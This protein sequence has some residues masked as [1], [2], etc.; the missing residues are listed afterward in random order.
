MIRRGFTAAA[1]TCALFLASARDAAADVTAFIGITP[2]PQNHTVRGFAFG[3]G[4]LV[5]GF[6]FEYANVV[7]DAVEGLPALRTGS[8]NV[9]LQMPVAVYGV[10][11]YGT[12]GGTAYR[13]TL[14]TLQET[15]WGTNLG[16]GAKI[17]LAGPLR[18]RLDYRVFKLRGD[19]I[20][21]TYQ[22]FYAGANLSFSGWSGGAGGCVDYR[23]FGFGGVVFFGSV[24]DAFFGIGAT[25]MLAN[26]VRPS[27]LG[28]EAIASRYFASS[29]AAAP[30]SSSSSKTDTR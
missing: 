7:E 11:L 4:L 14:G 6:E 13:E 1:L 22:R 15:S 28:G 3:F 5:V 20:H 30:L 24:G 27:L 17:R 23:G 16:G 29:S 18:V 26:S 8:G 19:A 25:D 10:Q 9:L 2:T 12:G 21:D